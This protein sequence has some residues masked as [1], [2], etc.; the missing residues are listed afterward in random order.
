MG[1]RRKGMSPGLGLHP[2]DRLSA[3]LETADQRVGGPVQ[4]GGQHGVE[5]LRLEREVDDEFHGRSGLMR[6]KAPLV[7]EPLERTVEQ[8]DVHRQGGRV[9]SHPGG[10]PLAQKNVFPFIAELSDRGYEVLIETGGYVSIEK[11][12]DKS[13]KGIDECFVD[14]L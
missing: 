1:T 3:V 5:K 9:P 8:A 13:R 2:V 4:I 7:R 14:R 11:V 12:F 6:R 10:E